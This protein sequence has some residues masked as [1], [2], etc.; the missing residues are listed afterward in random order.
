M[1]S[2]ST[3]SLFEFMG[4]PQ[5]SRGAA[6]ATLFI[7]SGVLA[8]LVAKVLHEATQWSMDTFDP[9]FGCLFGVTTGVMLAHM[10]VRIL[11]MLCSTQQG[12]P[13]FLADSGLGQELLYFKTYHQVADFLISFRDR[14]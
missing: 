1:F 7:G 2:P 13:T 5:A 8:L 6:L 14:A 10:T 3:A 9:I 11:A 4:S 12:L